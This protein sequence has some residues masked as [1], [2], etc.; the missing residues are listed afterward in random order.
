[1]GSAQ[2]FLAISFMNE[3]LLFGL[4]GKHA[5][6]DILVHKVLTYSAL[7]CALFPALECVW[8]HNPL[9]VAGRII[10]TYLHGAWFLAAARM[11]YEGEPGAG[12]HTT[13]RVV[14]WCWVLGLT[15]SMWCVNPTYTGR[16]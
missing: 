4:H 13:W 9:L 15:A 12:R 3:A 14:H 10:A 2:V 16:G 7:A 8:L 6:M 1:M 11:M 5:P